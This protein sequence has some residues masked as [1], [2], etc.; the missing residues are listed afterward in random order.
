MLRGVL[1]K[2]SSLPNWDDQEKIGAPL[3][4]SGTEHGDADWMVTEGSGTVAADMCMQGKSHQA[5]FT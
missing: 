4:D 5:V 1:S 3:L 2:C